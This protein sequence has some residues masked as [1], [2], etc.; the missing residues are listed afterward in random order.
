MVAQRRPIAFHSNPEGNGDIIVVPAEGGKPRNLTSH[1]A[2]DAFPTFSRDGRWIYFSSTRSGEP[3]IWKIPA[4]G[5]PALQVSAGLG[6]MAIESADGAYL[7]YTESRTTNTPRH[8]VARS[9]CWRR[10]P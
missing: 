6:I 1:P 5:G 2:T 3:R 9:C 4:S 8:V 10:P 7:Y